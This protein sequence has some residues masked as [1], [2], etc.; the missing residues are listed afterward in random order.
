MNLVVLKISCF[1]FHKSHVILLSNC[2]LAPPARMC[3]LFGFWLNIGSVCIKIS[4]KCIEFI[5]SPQ[6]VFACS[7]SCLHFIIFIMIYFETAWEKKSY[8]SIC[9]MDMFFDILCQFSSHIDLFLYFSTLL[10]FCS[11]VETM[12]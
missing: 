1:S 7:Y 9:S 4:S 3:Q 6:L 12:V 8:F 10:S 2:G 11:S 5:Y